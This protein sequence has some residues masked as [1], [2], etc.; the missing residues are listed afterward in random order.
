MRS[1]LAYLKDKGFAA[2]I[3]NSANEASAC[4]LIVRDMRDSSIEEIKFLQKSAPVAA[5]DD[6]G[7]GREAANKI[8]DLLPHPAHNF[9]AGAYHPEAFLYGYEFGK[10]LAALGGLVYKDTDFVMYS[11]ADAG[12]AEF[13][14]AAAPRELSGVMF[15][16]GRSLKIKDGKYSGELDRARAGI[17]LSA[18]VL[19]SHFG[20]TMYEALLGGARIV[21]VNP[22][23]YHDLLSQSAGGLIARSFLRE[24][25][26]PELVAETIR[27][28]AACGAAKKSVEPLDVAKKILS[29]MDN[30]VELI[31]S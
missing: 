22:S 12:A 30:F 18:N 31:F 24:A 5:L 25:A 13:L 1:L 27:R 23:E 21:A 29:N 15:T 7:S 2:N 17:I 11:G 19:V 20:I 6:R 4:D 14:L 26:A 8:I 16:Q 10:S 9:E 28:E 3:I